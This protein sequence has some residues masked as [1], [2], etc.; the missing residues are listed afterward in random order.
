M[1]VTTVPLPLSSSS[2]A[3]TDLPTIRKH[4][5]SLPSS[6]WVTAKLVS[7]V[8]KDQGKSSARKE[9]EKLWGWTLF[10]A[11]VPLEAFGGEGTEVALIAYAGACLCLPLS[12]LVC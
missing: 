12:S 9:G 6:A 7:S 10:E 2:S 11:E 8:E 5:S 3:A 4:A 1:H